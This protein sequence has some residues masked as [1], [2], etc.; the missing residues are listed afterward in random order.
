VLHAVGVYREAL[1]LIRGRDELP[2]TELIEQR[3]APIGSAFDDQPASLA[4]L[5]QKK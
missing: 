5:H 3:L 1:E 2:A 4:A